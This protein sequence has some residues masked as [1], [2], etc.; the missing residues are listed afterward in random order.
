ML[1]EALLRARTMT[2]DCRHECTFYVV[3]HTPDIPL[4]TF[5]FRFPC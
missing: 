2:V 5:P 3:L 4:H 1:E